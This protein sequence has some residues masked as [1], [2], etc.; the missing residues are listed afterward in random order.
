MLFSFTVNRHQIVSA[1]EQ[2]QQL[3]RHPAVTD[4]QLIA[5]QSLRNDI[6]LLQAREQDGAPWY[7]RFGLSHHSSLLAALMPW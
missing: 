2:A 1:A 5:L 7:Q 6:G 4:A 3:V